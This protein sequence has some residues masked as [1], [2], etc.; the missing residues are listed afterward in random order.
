VQATFES[1]NERTV[2][3][4]RRLGFVHEATPRHEVDVQRID[5]MVWSIMADEWPSTPACALAADAQAFDALGE[6]MF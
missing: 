3:L 2:H 4:M 1:T 5:E 6:R